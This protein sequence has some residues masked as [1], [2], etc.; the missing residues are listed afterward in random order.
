MRSMYSVFSNKIIEVSK[1]LNCCPESEKITEVYSNIK[2]KLLYTSLCVTTN[3]NFL[4]IDEED[5][6]DIILQNKDLQDVILWINSK[7]L[8]QLET[9]ESKTLD[10][11]IRIATSMLNNVVQKSNIKPINGIIIHDNFVKNL[12]EVYFDLKT[13]DLPF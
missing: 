1:T 8:T 2:D 5:M 9:L 10:V 6:Y 13:D 12:K 4:E 3:S 7:I 11:R